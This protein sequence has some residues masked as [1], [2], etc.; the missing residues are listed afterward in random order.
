MGF[1]PGKII[2]CLS[3][4]MAL[5]VGHDKAPYFPIEISRVLASSRESTI[6][7][8]TGLV[9]LALVVPLKL[10]HPYHYMAYVGVLIVGLVDDITSWWDHMLGVGLIGLAVLQRAYFYHTTLKDQLALAY[11]GGLFAMRVIVKLYMVRDVY[12]IQDIMIN[13]TKDPVLLGTFQAAGVAQWMVFLIIIT[14]VF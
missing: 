10:L 8:L 14:F 1:L 13:G 12:L 9:V 3:V 6:I 5:Y 4:A 11:A 7:F 2:L